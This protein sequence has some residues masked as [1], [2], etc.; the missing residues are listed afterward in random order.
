MGGY[1]CETEIL[2]KPAQLQTK[3]NSIVWYLKV[4]I[5]HTLC[6]GNI[7]EDARSFCRRLIYLSYQLSM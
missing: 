7:E 4:V 2:T 5:H 3:V 6:Q 1:F